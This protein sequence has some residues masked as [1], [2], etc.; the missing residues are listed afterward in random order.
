MIELS[1]QPRRRWSRRERRLAQAGGVIAVVL[2]AIVL[3]VWWSLR[4]EAAYVPGEEVEGRTAALEREPPEDAPALT[5]TDVTAEAGIDF[6]HFPA[7]RSSS[8][9]E[10]MGSGAAWGDYDDDGWPDLFVV[11]AVPGDRRGKGPGGEGSR[12]DD[13]SPEGRSKLYRNL[14]DGTFRD[15]SREVGLEVSGIGM[16]AAW[17][18]FD[19]D[20]DLDLL[21]SAYP[22][23]R[24]FRQDRDAT[25]GAVEAISFTEV[26][27]EAGLAGPEGFWSAVAWG[28]YDRD[29]DLDLYVAGYVQFDPDVGGA[30]SQYDTDV[31][32]SL[33]PSAFE[34]ERNL[35]F[36]NRGDGTFVEIA[37]EAGVVD[38]AGRGLGAAWIDFD[39]DGW[40]DLY[41]ANDVSDNALYLN[42]RDGTFRNV[43]HPALVA[44]YR[45]AMGI[46]T[47]DWDGDTDLDLFIT[48]WVAQ[49]NAL[50]SNLLAQFAVPGDS[51]RRLQFRDD[52]DRFGLG[53]IALDYVGWATSFVD[54]DNDGRLDLFVV[55]GHTFQRADDPTRLIGMRDQLFWNAGHERGFYEI[56]PVVGDWFLREEVGRG[57][58]AADYDRDGDID[59]FIVNHSAPAVLLRNDGENGRWLRVELEGARPGE[60]V[61]GSSVRLLSADSVVAVA[62]YG[63]QASYLSQNEASVHFGLGEREGIDSL[64][65]VWPDGNRS[66]ARQVAADGIL[67]V[68]WGGGV[69][70]R[71]PLPAL[72]GKERVH[73]FWETF[74]AAGR[75]R[76]AGEVAEALELY[77]QASRL[78]PE[79]EDALYYLGHMAREGGK[80]GEA[81]SAWRRLVALNS[82]SARAYTAL[83][84]L[85]LC[86]DADADPDP[87]AARNAFE[88][89][90]A[91]NPE[92]TG[93]WLDASIA[94]LAAG[95]RAEGREF[96][97]HV[98]QTDPDN[99]AARFLTAYLVW[100]GGDSAAAR[101][102]FDRRGTVE[103]AGPEASAEGDTET[104]GAMTA[105]GGRCST[106]RTMPALPGTADDLLPRFDSLLRRARALR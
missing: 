1:R 64:V 9:L 61:L 56:G 68:K 101:A 102:E 40:P 54:F 89:V 4:P 99:P 17:A 63:S 21:V 91:L 43:S 72:S 19:A 47:G 87:G 78:N 7:T 70:W 80:F 103:E 20:G 48:H 30:S 69:E 67:R 39:E 52:A 86:T 14:G 28:D 44:D 6:R 45:G 35:L 29:G 106:L 16:A 90:I 23:L 73:R 100:S 79:H 62:A 13:P 41:V 83:G 57:G 38:A 10:D 2:V 60:P 98:L 42:G 22:G 32:A 8:I 77:L 24:L 95:D 12:V 81:E 65:V 84:W 26:T 55:N 71:A 88:E 36:R 49:E 3:G 31:S 37:A 59:L 18:D 11:N 50:Y 15:V 66:T 75:A 46:A 76:I 27:A 93:V 53:Q 92:H 25:S 85:Y 96:A 58:A 34:P 97:E 74:R 5:F 51:V 33:N 105:A 94:A 104:G 82:R